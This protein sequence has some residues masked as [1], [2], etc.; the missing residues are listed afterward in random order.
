MENVYE[1][2]DTD[3][4]SLG[5][6]V[7]TEEVVN[8][9]YPGRYQ[10]VRENNTLPPIITSEAMK[11]RFTT[12]EFNALTAFVAAAAQAQQKTR[13]TAF[14]DAINAVGGQYYLD[15]SFS[16]KDK[17]ATVA[18]NVLTSERADVVFSPHVSQ[19]EAP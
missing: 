9:K 1:V 14:L 8:M 19:S 6:I 13:L 3:G 16:D 12:D 4:K 10:F 18:A 5:I 15:P 7:A 17:S 2:F 11:K